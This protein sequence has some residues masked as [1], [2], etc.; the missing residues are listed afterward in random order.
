MNNYCIYVCMHRKT[1][2]EKLHKIFGFLEELLWSRCSFWKH[3]VTRSI[4]VLLNRDRETFGSWLGPSTYF[5]IY[6]YEGNLIYKVKGPSGYPCECTR[7]K[8]AAFQVG[9]FVNNNNYYLYIIYWFISYFEI[10][11]DNVKLSLRILIQ[12]IGLNYM[13]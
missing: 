11:W 5:D 6:N 3:Q 8:V 9:F 12:V 13:K 10:K 7:D 1:V 2:K 4:V